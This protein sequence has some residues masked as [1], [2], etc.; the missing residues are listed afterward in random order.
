MD[1]IHNLLPDLS[2]VGAAVDSGHG[3]G[4]IIANPDGSGVITVSYTHLDVYKR[5]GYCRAAVKGFRSGGRGLFHSGDAGSPY[6]NF[7]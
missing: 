3:P 6:S 2:G 4:N 7:H 5:Q 1:F